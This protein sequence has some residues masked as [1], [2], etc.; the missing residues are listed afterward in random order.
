MARTFEVTEPWLKRIVDQVHGL[1]YGVVQITV[2]D[3]QIVQID[4][5]ERSRY[6]TPKSSIQG[7]KRR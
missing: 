3:G 7:N 4:R 2:H 5:T 1:S 6:D